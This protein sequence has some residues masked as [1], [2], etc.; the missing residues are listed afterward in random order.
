MRRAVEKVLFLH[1][2]V[3]I[4]SLFP[5]ALPFLRFLLSRLSSTGFTRL[6]VNLQLRTVVTVLQKH[7]SYEPSF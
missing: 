5:S 7:F 3:C 4:P 6:A 2:L 1:F